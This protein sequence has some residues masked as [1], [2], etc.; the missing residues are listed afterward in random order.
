MSWTTK[1][2]NGSMIHTVVDTI[3]MPDCEDPDIMV[4]EYIWKWENSE[5][6]KFICEHSVD[7]PVWKRYIDTT[8][9][10]YI[11]KVRASLSEK[12]FIIY[13]LKFE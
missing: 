2:V 1:G 12:D 10:G 9:F 3:M 6:G 7:K 8:R 4:A 5:I 13:K 11:Y